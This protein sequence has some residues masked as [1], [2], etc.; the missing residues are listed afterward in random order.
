M[1]AIVDLLLL[2]VAV[3]YALFGVMALY[4]LWKLLSMF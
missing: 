4:L 2:L 3:G 1:K